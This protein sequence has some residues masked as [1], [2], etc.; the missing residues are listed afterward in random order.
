MDKNK[1]GKYKS[2]KDISGKVSKEPPLISAFWKVHKVSDMMLLTIEEV[3][4]AIDQWME[5][6]V[7][8]RIKIDKNWNFPSI[9]TKTLNDVRNK[10]T[11]LDKAPRIKYN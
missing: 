9:P 7:A 4:Q 6:Y 1:R 11:D 8:R 10:R 2:T 5:E 3:D